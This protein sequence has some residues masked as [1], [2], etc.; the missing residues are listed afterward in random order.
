MALRIG[1]GGRFLTS[2]LALCVGGTTGAFAQSPS[3]TAPRAQTDGVS[4]TD[5]ATPQTSVTS[6]S[7]GEGDIVVTGSRVARRLEDIPASV[8]IITRAEFGNFGANQ[9]QDLIRAIP[10]NTGSKPISVQENGVGTNQFNLRG[11]GYSSTLTLLNGRRAG[12]SPFT[13]ASGGNFV[14]INQFPLSMLERVEVL[15]DGASA[16]YGSEAVAGVVNLITRSGFR[17]F[18]VSGQVENGQN[19]AG[20]VS[21]AAGIANERGRLSLYGTYYKQGRV[22][23]SE[24]DWNKERLFGSGDLSR[25]VVLSGTGNPSTLRRVVRN[26]SGSF[27]RA[28]GAAATPDPDCVAAGGIFRANENGTV[29]QTTCR[30]NI[31]DSTSLINEEDRKQLFAEFAYDL[32]DSVELFGEAS[33]SRN[34]IRQNLGPVSYRNGLVSGTLELLIPGDHPFNFFIADPNNAGRV[35]YVGPDNWNPAINRGVDL[36]AD[37]RPFGVELIGRAAPDRVSVHNYTRSVTGLRADIAR[38]WKAEASYQYAE[39]AN[40]STVPLNF[41]ADILNQLVLNGTFNP[42]G[43]ASTRP[44]LVSPKNGVSRAGNSQSVID[45]FVVS[46]NFRSRTVQHVVDVA[47]TLERPFLFGTDLGLAVGG[48]YRSLALSYVPDALRAAGEDS[49]SELE[50]PRTGSQDVWAAFT[51]ANFRISEDADLQLAVR[52]EDYGSGIGSTTDPQ[53]AVRVALG[54]IVTLRGRV[55]TSFQ[56]PTLNQTTTTLV[57]AFLNDPVGPGPNGLVCGVAGLTSN[58]IV[59][60][61]GADGLKP[62]SST[63]YSAGVTVAPAAGLRFSVDYWR[64]NYNDLIAP[65]T[66]AQAIVNNDCADGIPNDPR[67][68]RDAAGRVAQV[69]STYENIGRVETAGLDFNLRYDSDLRRVGRLGL[70][71]DATYVE[72]FRV[73]NGTSVFDGVGSRNATNNFFPIPDWR[74]SGGASF[75]SG[76]HTATATARYIAGYRNDQSNNAPIDSQTTI[77]VQY[78]LDLGSLGIGK[79]TVLSIGADNVFDVDPPALRRFGPD[80]QLLTFPT[81]AQDRP[82]YDPL[83]GHS[84]QGRTIYVRIL[85]RF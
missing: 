56:A 18:E 71:L 22:L 79:A 50:F 5:Q 28:P 4:L 73:N 48:Q 30:F 66:P 44:N 65:A 63:N 80:G 2:A 29:D 81:V 38:G 72:R 60:V 20:S 74:I 8:Q 31:G 84:I 45:Q 42:F 46:E 41:K 13:D 19:T 37:F 23:P 69:N 6:D 36:A 15:K 34:T 24:F 7:I 47:T 51:E 52:Y 76:R 58:A 33:F 27:V 17:G 10:S 64:Y 77:D 3:Q 55:G 40:D 16:I 61:S 39:A 70:F 53:A 82:G 14:D 54:K 11:L 25:A 32:S 68:V 1:L 35:I 49:N 12:I 62:Q 67:V 59:S 83:A 26:A 57:R 21:I 75:A 85:Q 78:G 9:V 43:T